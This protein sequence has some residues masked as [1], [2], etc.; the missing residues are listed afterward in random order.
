[1]PEITIKNVVV[2]KINGLSNAPKELFFVEKPP[3]DMVLNA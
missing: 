1:M 2:H 3:V